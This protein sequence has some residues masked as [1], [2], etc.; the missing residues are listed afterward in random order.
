MLVC[1]TTDANRLKWQILLI[2]QIGPE[3][4]RRKGPTLNADI[5][6]INAMNGLKL[7]VSS[8]VSLVAI[9]L[10]IYDGVIAWNEG[11]IVLL[12][13]LAGGYIAARV[14]RQLPQ[15]HVRTFVILTSTAITIY[16]FY[17]IYM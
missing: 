13:T 10:F 6:N 1:S 2:W 3:P 16:F 14:S 17:D 7:L 15:A 12:G 5:A 4:K 11:F 8:T 9:A